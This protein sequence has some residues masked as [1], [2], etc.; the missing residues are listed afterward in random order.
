MH[1]EKVASNRFLVS[2]I[3]EAIKFCGTFELAL[4]GHD[5]SEN[6][7]NPGIFQGLIN[8]T[9]EIDK[10]LKD[11]LERAT[12]FKG[13]S[14]EIQNDLLDC[15]FEVYQEIVS[16]EIDNAEF[17]GIMADETT[18]VSSKLQTVLIFRYC[19]D[20]KPVER[21]WE[22]FKS[23]QQTAE[24]LS[25]L[26]LKALEPLVAK[27]PN[28]L[29]AQSYDG[30][31]V[32]SGKQSGVQARIKEKYPVAH[33]VHCYAH[34]LNLIM[35]QASSQNNDVRLFF[36]NLSEIPAF[37]SNSCQRVAFL[38][39]I[40]KRKIPRSVPTRWNFKSRTV[41]VV[42]EY[43][44][45]LIECME[46]IEESPGVNVSTKTQAGAIRRLL[47][48]KSFVFWLTFF[49]YVMPH[50]DIF[51]NELQRRLI[52]SVQIGKCLKK[53]KESIS[54]IRNEKLYDILNEAKALQVTETKRRKLNE[55]TWRASAIEVCDVIIN[56]AEDR[57]AYTD[58][59]NAANLFICERFEL[60]DRSFP[61]DYFKRTIESYPMLEKN[62]LKTEL[63]LLYS[64]AEYRTFSSCAVLL[65]FIIDSNLQEVFTETIKLLNILVTMPMTTVEAERNFS[66]LKRIK[67]FLRSTMSQDRLNALACLSIEQKLIRSI[68][69]FNEKVIDKF[70]LKKDRR[71]DLVFKR[72]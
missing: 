28:K 15:I 38:D 68:P 41:N 58:Q 17:L 44:E 4:R 60:Y 65:S 1:N 5:E 23:E 52:D 61:D 42:F 6:S 25:N 26:I 37:F 50:V 69:D 14:K 71:I 67:T 55:D 54:N 20:G 29:I 70:A 33:F 9:A 18:D 16:A 32:M 56:V 59:L 63:T 45:E 3:V 10:T 66:S 24:V 51:F 27:N 22:F 36:G 57:F 39:R 13:T 46:E 62:R 43:K 8:Y 48:E 12:V 30:A 34:Q 31:A 47:Q 49:H 21:F 72:K 53:F 19:K 11:H 64:S 2:K 7:E 35:S 40:V